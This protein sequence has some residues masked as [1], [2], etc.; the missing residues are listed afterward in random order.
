MKARWMK[1]RWGLSVMAAGFLFMAIGVYRQEV[2]TVLTKAVAICLESVSYTH[3]DVYKRQSQER[4][5]IW[6]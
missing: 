4:R 3:L 2:N 5:R 1:N 6:C